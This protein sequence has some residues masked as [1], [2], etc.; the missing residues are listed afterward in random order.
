MASQA[1]LDVLVRRASGDDLPGLAELYLRARAAAPMPPTVHSDD[2]VRAWVRGWDLSSREVWVAEVGPAEVCGYAV[3]EGDWLHS[4]YV[5][6]EA[7]GR[8]VGSVLLDL[9]KATRPQGFCLWVFESNLPARA[10]YERHGLA[11]LELTDGSSNEE[12]TPDL[13]M[14]WPGQDPLT[15]LRGL[16]DEVDEQL[17]EL[18]ARRAALTRVVQDHRPGGGR[19]AAREQQIA[20]T[21]ARL[22][23]ALGQERIR[24]ILDAIIVESLD[25]AKDD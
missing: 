6:P 11:T 8:G 12:R 3:I 17:G 22:A 10:F 15:F 18:L 14:A 5:S 1:P 13:R 20:E 23:P 24:R 19:D 25:A 4:L 2:D 9:V 7:T 16:I 21:M